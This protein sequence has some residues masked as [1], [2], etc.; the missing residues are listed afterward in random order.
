MQTGNEVMINLSKHAGRMFICFINFD[1]E[2]INH[3][4]WNSWMYSC[5]LANLVNHRLDFEALCHKPIKMKT[6]V[7]NALHIGCTLALSLVQHCLA[8][9]S[10]VLV[11]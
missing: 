5:C 4:Q 11:E 3:W 1:D 10:Q 7:F 9:L 2:P 6:H 8:I